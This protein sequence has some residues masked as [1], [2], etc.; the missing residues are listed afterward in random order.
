MW[1]LLG[2]FDGLILLI[3]IG[4]LLVVCGVVRFRR[5]MREDA[6][7]GIGEFAADKE[8]RGLL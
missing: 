2:H 5:Q 1:E 6:L 3:I 4:A 8:K 7:L